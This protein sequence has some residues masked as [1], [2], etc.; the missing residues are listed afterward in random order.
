M[1]M[2]LL[3]VIFVIAGKE[4]ANNSQG[5]SISQVCIRIEK[6]YLI[7]YQEVSLHEAYG[8]SRILW[9]F[10]AGSF[11]VFVWGV[12]SRVMVCVVIW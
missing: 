5:K 6:Y 12:S 11:Y 2:S 1:L 4:C 7:L 9:S 3:H 10:S 8:I